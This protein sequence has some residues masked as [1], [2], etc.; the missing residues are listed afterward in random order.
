MIEVIHDPFNL[1]HKRLLQV[2]NPKRV[3]DRLTARFEYQTKRGFRLRALARHDQGTL[4]LQ[5]RDPGAITLAFRALQ[6][7]KIAYK[8]VPFSHVLNQPK[9][10]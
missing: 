7:M 2:R 1:P 9:V 4:E 10:K 8:T 3:Q 6:E 5:A